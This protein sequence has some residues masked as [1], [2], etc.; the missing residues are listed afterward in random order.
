[1]LCGMGGRTRSLEQDLRVQE[2]GTIMPGSTSGRANSLGRIFKLQDFGTGGSA[3]F[4]VLFFGLFVEFQ[5]CVLV[6]ACVWAIIFC[7]LDNKFKE[8]EQMT[9]QYGQGKTLSNSNTRKVGID[10][11]QEIASLCSDIK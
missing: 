1:M 7:G 2:R 11:Y 10:A 3:K 8:E 6:G 9:N 4:L 5:G